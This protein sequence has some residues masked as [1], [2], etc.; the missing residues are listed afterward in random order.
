MRHVRDVIRLKSSGIATREIARRVGA[1]PS[2]VR[3]T[4]RRFE[5]SGLSWPLPEDV[6]DSDLE[7][8]LF[9]GSGVGPG[10][11]RGHRRQN[12]H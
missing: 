8:R 2:T 10:T 1:A 3:L 12:S 7:A 9:T 6:T 5:A 11:R 4:L